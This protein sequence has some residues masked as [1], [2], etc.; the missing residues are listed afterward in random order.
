MIIYID[1]DYRCHVQN[2][3][4]RTAVETDAFDGKCGTYIEGFRFIPEGASWTR[5]D[6]VVFEG[7]MVCPAVDSS[8]L[9]RAQAAYVE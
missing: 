3:D 1:A 4:G 2:A 8:A 6:G 5:S 7:E 9:E